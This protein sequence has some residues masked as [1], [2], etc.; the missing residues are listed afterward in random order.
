MLE[1]LW[2][3]QRMLEYRQ[4]TLNNVHQLCQAETHESLDNKSIV[5]QVIKFLH[6]SFVN[7]AIVRNQ[8]ICYMGF[9]FCYLSTARGTCRGEQRLCSMSFCGLWSPACQSFQ[10]DKQTG[11]PNVVFSTLSLLQ[12]LHLM[13]WCCGFAD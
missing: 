8:A 13:L 3:T 4:C 9:F 2:V 11:F 12:T 1:S 7:T 10:V 6:C 5:Q